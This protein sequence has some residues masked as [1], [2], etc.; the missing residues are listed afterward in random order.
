MQGKE[1]SGLRMVR[2]GDWVTGAIAREAAFKLSQMA[3]SNLRQNAKLVNKIHRCEREMAGE[4]PRIQ[5]QNLDNCPS[6]FR[7]HVCGAI[8]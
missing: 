6:T 8:F 5:Q 2:A 1:F 4:P 3:G 7:L